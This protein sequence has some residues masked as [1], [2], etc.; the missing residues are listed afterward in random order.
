MIAKGKTD[1]NP[2]EKAVQRRLTRIRNITK[3]Y[4]SSFVNSGVFRYSGP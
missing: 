2:E 4:L 1:H 3:P